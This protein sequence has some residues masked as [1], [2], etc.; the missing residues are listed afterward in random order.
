MDNGG[1]NKPVRGQRQLS[2]NK[3]GQIDTEQGPT[4]Q[5]RNS[6]YVH[7]DKMKTLLGYEADFRVNLKW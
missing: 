6:A 7:K 3:R 4:F 1:Q 2:V 5:V